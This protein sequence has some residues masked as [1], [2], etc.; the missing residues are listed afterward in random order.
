MGGASMD[1]PLY[2]GLLDVPRVLSAPRNPPRRPG[3]MLAMGVLAQQEAGPR[4]TMEQE[5]REALINLR[6]AEAWEAGG[7]WARCDLG[8][9]PADA[10]RR[11]MADKAAALHTAS[12]KLCCYRGAEGAHK[13]MAKV[14]EEWQH[15]KTIRLAAAARTSAT[16]T[17]CTAGANLTP[18]ISAGMRGREFGNAAM[19]RAAGAPCAA[20]ALAGS[21]LLSASMSIDQ[22]CHSQNTCMRTQWARLQLP[23]RLH[24]RP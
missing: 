3:G 22:Q 17:L 10:S 12:A 19:P 13:F 2:D 15:L 20:S 11:T 8:G 18:P 5:Y 1:G 16:K 21:L 4:M 23:R 24:P 14:Q 9:L 6:L 7:R